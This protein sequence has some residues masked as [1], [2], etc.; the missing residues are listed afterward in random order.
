[1]EHIKNVH[2]NTDHRPS[3]YISKDS[4]I[5]PLSKQGNDGM[6]LFFKE[7]LLMLVICFSIL[8]LIFLTIHFFKSKYKTFQKFKKL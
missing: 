4:L 3:N 6:G 2:E 5:P 8:V 7:Y 1:M